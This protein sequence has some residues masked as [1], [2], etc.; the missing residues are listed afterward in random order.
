ARGAIEY[1]F[2]EGEKQGEKKGKQEGLIEGLIKGKQEGLIEGKRDGL[3][4]GIEALLELKYGLDGIAL[5]DKVKLMDTIEELYILKN[6]IKNSTTMENIEEYL[7][8]NS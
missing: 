6:L 5:I 1:S 7:R 3:I 8:R 4:E 2:S